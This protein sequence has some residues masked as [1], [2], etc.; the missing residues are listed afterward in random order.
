LKKVTLIT[1]KQCPKCPMARVF[2]KELKSEYK[3]EYEEIDA[4][5]KLG[6]SLVEDFSIMSVPAAI[7]QQ[8]GKEGV[9]F[10][11]LPSRQKVIEALEG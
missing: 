4:L 10:V 2:W 9:A 11:G 8:D 3:F 6:Q 5:T 1:T 7:V